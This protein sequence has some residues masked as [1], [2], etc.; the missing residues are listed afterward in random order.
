LKRLA[1]AVVP[2]SL[3]VVRLG[4]QD[5]LPDWAH[6]SSA[7]FSLT[8]TAAEVSI[9]CAAARVPEEIRA[10]RGWAL[11]ELQGP[12]PFGETGVLASFIAPLAAAGISVFALSTF[13]T[14]YV[15]VKAERL[16]EALAVLNQAGHR[17]AG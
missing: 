3:A 9:V 15:L 12:I 11:F 7:F 17:R 6:G 1:F 5:D 13:D 14:D 2:G 8:R 16:A 10:E 4:P